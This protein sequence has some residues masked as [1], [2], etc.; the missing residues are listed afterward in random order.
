MQKHG[1]IG[2]ISLVQEERFQLVTEDGRGFLFTLGRKA[3]LQISDLQGLQ[4]SHTRVR[5]E[6][7]GEPNTT[8][9]VVELVQPL[10][11]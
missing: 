3:S 9:G 6:Y 4:K 7:S 1:L 2:H 10:G 8:S 5:V 11:G